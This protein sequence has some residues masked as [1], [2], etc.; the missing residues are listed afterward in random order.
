MKKSKQSG[1]TLIELMIVVAIIGVLAAIA[2]PAYVSYQNKARATE[3]LLALG[4]AKTVI[5]EQITVDGL[6]QAELAAGA[7]S[8]T[9][10]GIGSINSEY[11]SSVA[12]EQDE[13]IAIGGAALSNLTL[14]LKPG[15]DADGNVSW[16]CS[17]DGDKQYA[18]ASC[19]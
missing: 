16:A 8:S 13:I 6:S 12:W 3:L 18:P 19:R 10:A 14:S 9:E 4:P 7:V 2:I 17:S 11:I 1:F 15:V 5:A